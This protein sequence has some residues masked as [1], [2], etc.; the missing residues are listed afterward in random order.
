MDQKDNYT[1]LFLRAAD[2]DDK[3]KFESARSIWWYNQRNKL[4]GG[5]RLTEVGYKFVIEEADIKEYVVPFPKDL[6]ITAQ[7]LIWLDKFI[8][9]PYYI[10]S[11]NII[12]FSERVAFELY[13]F[14]GDVYKM[15]AAKALSKHMAQD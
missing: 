8:A 15:G 4:E 1:L 9:G 12:V 14:S 11:K 7:I 5:L 10:N 6:K 3:E 13:L 2:Q